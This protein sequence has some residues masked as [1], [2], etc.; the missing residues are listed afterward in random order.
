MT[1]ATPG[2]TGTGET[3]NYVLSA[4]LSPN[5]TN[6]N[7]ANPTT[8]QTSNTKITITGGTPS[9]SPTVGTAL[10]VVS[11][12]GSF[13]PDSVT[14]SIS[15][16]T[17]TVTAASG[18]PNLSAGDALFGANIKVFTKIVGRLT[19]TGGTGTYTISP[20]QEVASSIIIDRAAVVAVTSAN[21]FTVSRL[22]DTGLSNAQICGGLCPILKADGVHTLGEVTL[23]NIVNYD[24]WSSGF[25]C[26]KGIDPNNIL[27][28]V[29][30][31]SKQGTWSELVQ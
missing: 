22:P 15:G 25:A 10:A 20:S 14:A 30:V 28:V 1:F 18:S 11:G 3:G 29:N 23:S 7:I 13:L 6:P 9:T 2:T 24:D 17:M 27:T 16:T 12:T 4:Q 21:S 31:M 5:N 19:G 8:M 26:V